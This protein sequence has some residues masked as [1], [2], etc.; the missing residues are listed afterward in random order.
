MSFFSAPDIAMGDTHAP[1]AIHAPKQAALSGLSGMTPMGDLIG[2]VA[3]AFAASKFYEASPSNSDRW[4]TDLWACYHPYGNRGAYC[5]VGAYVIV[6][7]AF[8]IMAAQGGAVCLHGFPVR[9]GETSP[10]PERTLYGSVYRTYMEIVQSGSIPV[11]SEPEAGA[12]FFRA[13]NDRGYNHAGIVIAANLKDDDYIT[14]VEA[15]TTVSGGSS[16]SKGFV[17]ITYSRAAYEKYLTRPLVKSPDAARYYGNTDVK[18][19]KFA[20]VA[21]NCSATH[22]PEVTSWQACLGIMITCG[23][24]APPPSAPPT[25]EC[26][27]G[28]PP[29]PRSDDDEYTPWNLITNDY[30]RSIDIGGGLRLTERRPDSG[31]IQRGDIQ[32]ADSCWVRYRLGTVSQQ[33]GMTPRDAEKCRESFIL[34]S[35]C[36]EGS[37]PAGR[38]VLRIPSSGDV[39]TLADMSQQ[40]AREALFSS[41]IPRND[42][43]GRGYEERYRRAFD[44]VPMLRLEKANVFVLVETSGL[45]PIFE[46]LGLWGPN[47]HFL[48]VDRTSI[49]GGTGGGYAE[50][51]AAFFTNDSSKRLPVRRTRASDTAGLLGKRIPVEG[52]VMPGSSLP[53]D[54]YRLSFFDYLAGYETLGETRPL[55][56]VFTGEPI[57]GWDAVVGPLSV[58]TGFI[59]GIGPVVSQA[60]G[61]IERI[62]Q[63]R[64]T[65]ADLAF[66]LTSQ[67]MTALGGGALGDRPFGVP[68]SVFR[69]IAGMTTRAE[70]VYGTLKAV[71]G[72]N[73]VQAAVAVAS[74]FGR[75]FPEAVGAVRSE[76]RDAERWIRNA[77]S[78]VGRVWNNTLGDVRAAVHN[79]ADGVANERMGGLIQITTG[80]DSVFSQLIASGTSLTTS[81]TQVPL[82]QELLTT[83]GDPSLLGMIPGANKIAGNIL[84]NTLFYGADVQSPATHA[85]LAGIATGKR[86]LD[87]ALD[88]L[89]LSALINKA[90]DFARK[91]W[92][93]DLP[94]TLP[95]EKR[96]CYA[97][98][99]S[100]VT[101]VECCAPKVRYCGVCYESDSVPQC[102]PGQ[103]R[104]TDGCCVEVPQEKAQDPGTGP[105]SPASGPGTPVTG[106]GAGSGVPVGAE[107]ASTPIVPTPT[108]PLPDCIRIQNG[109]YVYCP[110]PICSVRSPRPAPGPT[111]PQYEF[112]ATSS[113]TTTDIT[114]TVG[115]PLETLMRRPVGTDMY[116]WEPVAHR[117]AGDGTW[118]T[119]ASDVVG[120]TRLQ[121]YVPE[122]ASPGG[123]HEVVTGQVGTASAPICYEARYANAPRERWYA[124]IAGAW[125]ELVDC[126]PAPTEDCCTETRKELSAISRAVTDMGALLQ[127]VYGAV[128]TTKDL[129]ER[130]ESVVKETNDRVKETNDRLR[131]TN[132][133]IET[134]NAL[135]R[136]S[137]LT[138]ET[139]QRSIMKLTEN[140]QRACAGEPLDLADI[141][142]DLQYLRSNVPVATT[143]YDDTEVLRRLVALHEAVLSLRGAGGASTPYDDSVLRR[144]VE[145]IRRLIEARCSA[146]VAQSACNY[147]TRFDMIEASMAN[148]LALVRGSGGREATVPGVVTTDEAPI[149]REI[150]RAIAELR[151]ASG[152]S[153]DTAFRELTTTLVRVEEQ[154]RRIAGHEDID[155]RPQ[156]ALIHS[157]LERIEHT[158]TKNYD[159]EFAQIVALL[160][161]MARDGIRSYDKRFDRLEEMITTA[162]AHE[163]QDYRERFTRLE[164]GLDLLREQ[165]AGS[166]HCDDTVR[167]YF[168]DIMRR[169]GEVTPAP[170][171][172]GAP[173][174]SA[175]WE[176]ALRIL[177]ELRVRAGAGSAANPD[178]TRQAL[179]ELRKDVAM[180][181]SR[182]A[183]YA[184][185]RWTDITRLLNLVL[186][187]LQTNAE[188][189]GGE[190]QPMTSDPAVQEV[191]ALLKAMEGMTRTMASSL[192]RSERDLQALTAN[193]EHMQSAFT[194]HITDLR[195]TAERSG[196]TTGDLRERLRSAEEDYRYQTARY[197]A[198][199]SAVRMRLAECV[200]AR[201]EMRSGKEEPRAKMP[202]HDTTQERPS[203]RSSE[204]GRRRPDAS[205]PDCPAVVERHERTI[206]RYP[207]GIYQGSYAPSA[208]HYTYPQDDGEDA[209]ECDD[210]CDGCHG[211]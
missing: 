208:T 5:V 16:S 83:K 143:R 136:E 38:T 61:T 6:Q 168:T 75:Q 137:M 49:E 9:P 170:P 80:I 32:V 157:A 174:S 196:D 85:A 21:R 74:E 158:N 59:P 209:G 28:A 73:A 123:T 2:C 164:R 92:Q 23:P 103:E 8:E 111:A 39:L 192:E 72:G 135:V 175:S 210:D 3:R 181:T 125:V 26:D 116:A 112:A 37:G 17:T 58:I 117:R 191:F 51:L 109:S 162:T 20:Y 149:L 35:A 70:R 86:V 180:A 184:E 155:V 107:S 133:R 87:G 76:F 126:C 66:A 95:P 78:E 62:R 65:G 96:E 94:M 177:R 77:A 138:T 127:R 176:E 40:G 90:A 145:D 132:E 166:P 159:N 31:A 91:R 148:L 129:G 194:R 79:I 195:E 105:A 88:S 69:D 45:Y 7:T 102:P 52:V 119:L 57:S 100:V 187:R 169:L 84:S 165:C 60:I 25:S 101:G 48:R 114:P 139:M 56:V 41:V 207:P 53:V 118:Y 29:A 156:L 42:F 82:V 36:D 22:V 142:R 154:I 121:S 106:T 11:G 27:T 167:S 4:I 122:G 46:Q 130:T 55:V 141:R 179:E 147:D 97:H 15:N 178:A 203:R 14:T 151:T 206:Y 144:D 13:S 134:T 115:M 98:E 47:P 43:V 68:G 131:E 120:G 199:L 81:V 93:F 99:I 193:Y 153:Y 34:T 140:V 211:A 64:G 12:V 50:R 152:P 172:A 33:G 204:N 63:T 197:E 10:N 202:D 186:T 128:V 108:R 19:W 89:M 104:D 198:E 200:G 146:G 18:G 160:T 188:Q 71:Q 182:A 124:H 163:A 150:Q 67:I 173:D 205:C 190:S 44:A 30:P 185:G 24:G 171:N 201:E 183:T 189:V 113:V 1:S 54:A 161:S 110:P